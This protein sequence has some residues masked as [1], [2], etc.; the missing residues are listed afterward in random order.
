MCLSSA[1]FAFC[2]S[3]LYVGTPALLSWHITSLVNSAVHLWG[4]EPYADA[5]SASCTAKNTGG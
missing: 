1:K 5:M 4:D 3:A 2:A